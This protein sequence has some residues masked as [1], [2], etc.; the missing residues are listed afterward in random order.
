MVSGMGDVTM[1]SP[2]LITIMLLVQSD[3]SQGFGDR[4]P[5]QSMTIVLPDGSC[6]SRITVLH[7][8]R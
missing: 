2:A 7:F 8:I 3:K 6:L 1:A 4:V 5:K